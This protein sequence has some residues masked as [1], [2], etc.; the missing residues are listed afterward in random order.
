MENLDDEKD[1]PQSGSLFDSFF[2]SEDHAPRK[3]LLHT[4]LLRDDPLYVGA[5]TTTLGDVLCALFVLFLT[6]HLS[7]LALQRILD[8]QHALLPPNY[9]PTKA[10]DLLGLFSS[11]GKLGHA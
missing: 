11:S 4:V 6:S 2:E 1:P 8:L 9:L 7:K 5:K 10:D 3:P